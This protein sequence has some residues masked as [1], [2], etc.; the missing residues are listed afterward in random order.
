[1]GSASVNHMNW[2]KRKW[3]HKGKWV[4][5]S[6]KKHADE[7]TIS[8]LLELTRMSSESGLRRDWKLRLFRDLGKSLLFVSLCILFHF[9]CSLQIGFPCL[10]AYII[11][12]QIP[13][14]YFC[15]RVHV[16]KC[17]VLIPKRLAE[18]LVGSVQH[19]STFF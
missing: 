19:L 16:D 9:S 7:D 1:M 8:S 15:P 2:K 11:A 18:C 6:L 13:I 4:C 3:F 10:S 17:R 12:L 5:W 14:P